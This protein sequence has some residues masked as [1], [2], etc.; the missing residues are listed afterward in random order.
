MSNK[1][2]AMKLSREYTQAN[3]TWVLSLI[4]TAVLL[5][6]SF[7]FKGESLKGTTFSLFVAYAFFTAI[8]LFITWMVRKDLVTF[9]EIRNRTRKLGYIQLLSLLTGNIFTVA[10]AFNLINKKKT[11]EYTFAVYMVLTQVFI[12]AI[13]ALNLF[14]PYVADTFLVAMFM[15]IA[16]TDLPSGCIAPYG[17]IC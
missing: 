17:K 1:I 13:S 12:I 16:I 14:K 9:G 10:F 6:N 7:D 2:H 15:L 8:Q 5:F 3:F 4:L 11:P